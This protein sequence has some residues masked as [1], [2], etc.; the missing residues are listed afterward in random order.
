M[1]SPPIDDAGTRFE[2]EWVVLFWMPYD[3]DLD[4][5]AVEVLRQLDRAPTSSRVAWAAQVDRR[6]P[7][8]MARIVGANGRTGA[9]APVVGED[10]SSP[11]ALA[12]FLTW[13]AQRF[14]SR[15]YA[16][17]MLDHGGGLPQI[18]LDEQ[19][20]TTTEAG[21]ERPVASWMQVPDLGRELA[22][23]RRAERG[24]LELVFLQVC[25]KATLETAYELR[26]VSKWLMASQLP[27][28]APN[29]YYEGVFA[30]LVADARVDG[31]GLGRAIARHEDP[32]MFASY[33]LIESAE[34]ARLVG[35]VEGLQDLGAA[36]TPRRVDRY[37]YWTDGYVDLAAWAGQRGGPTS[38][39]SVREEIRD[40]VE[41]FVSPAGR[42]Y[43]TP[44]PPE[45]LSGLSLHIPDGS[46]LLPG[47]ERMGIYRRRRFADQ[48]PLTVEE[49]PP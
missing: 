44:L 36:P 8:G 13:A 32:A 38:E 12:D 3:N 37:E 4:A 26:G 31:Q 14:E 21:A 47:Y 41:V 33:S 6:G 46:G 45:D 49:T 29:A 11:E 25:V 27:I 48:L 23:F 15:R 22:R 20:A 17:V 5:A 42:R 19:R 18:S 28:G 16:V 7:G 40:V 1:D 2:Q 34:I 24:E 35:A 30:E 39:A 9:P 10:S 43:A